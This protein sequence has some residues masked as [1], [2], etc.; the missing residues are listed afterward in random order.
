MLMDIGQETYDEVEKVVEE[1]VD[2]PYV[3]ANKIQ[4]MRDATI[5]KLFGRVREGQKGEEK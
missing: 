4:E 5:L 3:L 2:D 1:Y